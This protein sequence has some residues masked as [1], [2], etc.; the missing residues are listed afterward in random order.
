MTRG[1]LMSAFGLLCTLACAGGDADSVTA[2]EDV[3]ADAVTVGGADDERPEYQFGYVTGLVVLDGGRVAVADQINSNVRVFDVDGAHLYSFGRAGAGP[4]E[5]QRPC[6]LALDAQQRLWVRDGG[7]ARYNVYRLHDD[8]AAFAWQV[9]MSHADVNRQAPL[10]FDSAGNVIDV[11]YY[12]DAATGGAEDARTH[13]DSAGQ[14]IRSLVIRRPPTDSTSMKSVRRDTPGGW[15]IRFAHQPYGP[16]ELTAHSPTGGYAHAL[17]SRYGIDWRDDR[18]RLIRHLALDIPTGPELS[19]AEHE[20]GEARLE[21]QRNFIGVS[22]GQ[23]GFDV[24]SHK[25][26]LNALFFDLDGRLWVELSVPAGA[27]RQAHLYSV[28]GVLE[29]RVAWPRRIDLSLGAISG[30]V[31][32]GI[33]HDELD[34]PSLVRLTGL[35]TAGSND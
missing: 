19:E 4:G 25:P 11:G 23:L 12:R 33:H 27:D 31:V 16:T 7:N 10:T 5:L 18:G 6:C 29:R 2:P 21:E 35:R 24:P 28:D 8:S 17:S 14:V 13:V 1:R 20:R 26:P 15:E 34:I 32:W 9:R 30:D 22:R 3:L